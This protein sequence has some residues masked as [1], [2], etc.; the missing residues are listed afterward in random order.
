MILR[1][2]KI[3]PIDLENKEN[4]K[5]VEEEQFQIIY[6][7]NLYDPFFILKRK[8]EKPHFYT[9]NTILLSKDYRI[10]ANIDNISIPKHVSNGYFFIKEKYHIRSKE[11]WN[12]YWVW[13]R[14]HIYDRFYI[15]YIFSK[16]HISHESQKYVLDTINKIPKRQRFFILVALTNC[17]NLSEESQS[18]LLS[19]LEKI[20]D[21]SDNNKLKMVQN[22]IH[23]E[24]LT[25]KNQIYI[26]KKYP[27]W[28][29]SIFSS[30]ATK[31]ELFFKMIDI[32]FSEKDFINSRIFGRNDI[33]ENEKDIIKILDS[34]CLIN[35]KIFHDFLFGIR[36]LERSK[37]TNNVLQKIIKKINNYKPKEKLI[38][39]LIDSIMLRNIKNIRLDKTKKQF[40]I[41]Y[42]I[43]L[44]D[45]IRTNGG[46]INHK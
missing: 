38:S 5:M 32:Y 37:I 11:L 46:K 3:S 20:E 45:K 6:F 2:V 7:R 42:E 36:H 31:K 16:N 44:E 35:F 29:D 4:N 40:V 26:Y 25:Q 21:R 10:L 23:N 1:L 27:E 14:N 12:R 30:F 24:S 13:Q 33:F 18:F 43:N 9:E 39:Q 19:I 15:D 17:T 41:S 8:S 22:L 28:R 34:N